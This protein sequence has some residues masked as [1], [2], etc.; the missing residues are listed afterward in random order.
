MLLGRPDKINGAYIA[1][2]N[3]VRPDSVR[4]MCDKIEK[5]VDRDRQRELLARLDFSEFILYGSYVRSSDD[6]L[7][8]HFSTDVQQF[9]SSWF[10]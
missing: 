10:F 2:L 5:V 1:Q 8:L 6:L 3:A 9:A 4:R 7:S